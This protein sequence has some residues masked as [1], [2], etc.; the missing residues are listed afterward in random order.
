MYNVVKR[1]G[2]IAEFDISKISKAITK[3]LKSEKEL[4]RY[5]DR[6]SLAQDYG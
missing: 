2:K 1:D 5:R 4:P 6:S 3:A